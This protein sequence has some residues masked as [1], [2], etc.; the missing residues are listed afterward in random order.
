MGR[1][2]AFWLWGGAESGGHG[3][4]RG[5]G[6]VGGLMGGGGRVG[7]RGWEPPIWV[8]ARGWGLLWRRVAG[9]GRGCAGGEGP[10]AGRGGWGGR[11]ELR[12][13]EL[14]SW[15]EG[16]AAELRWGLLGLGSR[17]GAGRWDVV[18]G[19]GWGVGGWAARLGGGGGGGHLW[20][21][22]MKLLDRV[23]DACRRRHY[24]L[25]TADAY[26]QWVRE[27]VLFHGKQHPS[28]LGKEE[29]V[30]WLNHLSGARRLAASTQNQA[31]CAIVFM[32][33]HVIGSD[34]GELDGLD[35]AKKPQKIPVVLTRVEVD[36]VLGALRGVHLLM[37]QLLYG[38]GLRLLECCT[39]RVQDVDQELGQLIVHAGKGQKDRVT[40]LPQSVLPALREQVDAVKA[41]FEQDLR[42]SGYG[43]ATLPFAMERKLGRAALAL[44]WQYVFPGSG[45]VRADDGRLLRHHVDPTALQKAV[46]R[47]VL[48][49]EIE[50]RASCH[51]L[52]HSFATHL[53]EAGT[54]IRTIQTL[55]G[56]SSLK[57]TM[58]YTHVVRRGALGAISPLD[59]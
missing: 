51:T 42:V 7:Q 53:L 54:D 18:Q 29:I 8:V 52:R 35:R 24:S 26:A 16:G 31:L 41:L 21:F 56:H 9:G 6:A 46:H 34:V 19:V 23:R 47:A 27:F 32:Y 14:A 10:F 25:R 59:R 20:R 33:R 17:G 36:A 57:T 48:R 1:G 5:A 11:R 15:V 22:R 50:K 39:L 4:G 28:T 43:G 55:L 37:S 3:G 38:A 58:I 45:L 44:P 13:Q 30:A 49:S 2:S 40:V 12:G